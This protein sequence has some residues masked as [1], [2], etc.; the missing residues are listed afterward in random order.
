MRYDVYKQ[1]AKQYNNVTILL[2]NC[3]NNDNK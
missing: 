3:I 2:N 1:C